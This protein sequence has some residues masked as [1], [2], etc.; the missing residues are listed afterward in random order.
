MW[1][2]VL[3]LLQ[4]AARDDEA[5][6]DEEDLDAEKAARQPLGPGV[7]EQYRKHGQRPQTVE[8]GQVG[9][10]LFGVALARLLATHRVA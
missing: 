3:P 5:A 6:D 9:G 2:D 10:E 7:V 1:P 8:A 4:Q